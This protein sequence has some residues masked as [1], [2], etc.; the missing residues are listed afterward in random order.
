MEQELVEQQ[1]DHA[2]KLKKMI[3]VDDLDENFDLQ[4]YQHQYADC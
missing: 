2:S 1:T 4:E 3:D